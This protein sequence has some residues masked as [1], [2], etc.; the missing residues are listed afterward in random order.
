M[1]KVR[2]SELE[3]GLSSSGDQ[4]GVIQPSLPLRRYVGWT[5]RLW[6]GSRIGSSSQSVSVF[7]SP[8]TRMGLSFLSR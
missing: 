3:T 7:I 6:V 1:A 8:L 2:S 4:R 5:M